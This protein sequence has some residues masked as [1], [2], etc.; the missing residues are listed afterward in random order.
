MV[1]GP[2]RL[3]IRLGKLAGVPPELC[4]GFLLSRWSSFR[5][6]GLVMVSQLEF[7]TEGLPVLPSPQRLATLAI[8]TMPKAPPAG[9]SYCGRLAE[10]L[11]GPNRACP[12]DVMGLSSLPPFL[13][14]V[15][16]KSGG[17]PVQIL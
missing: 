16:D 13:P 1:S 7:C 9:L 2:H 11:G 4:H 14:H 17:R 12:Q 15:A 3:H 10:R 8:G 6:Q 5:W